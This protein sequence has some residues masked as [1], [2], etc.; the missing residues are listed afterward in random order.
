MGFAVLS[1]YSGVP[2]IVA[3]GLWAIWI[4]WSRGAAA[5]ALRAGALFS[6][7]AIGPMVLLLAYQWAAFGH[8]LFPAQRYMPPTR[9]SVY[10][11]NGMTLPTA[12]LL[13][14]NLFDP[15]YGLFVFCPMLVAA[16]AAPFLRGRPDRLARAARL[17][18]GELA[19]IFGATIA[20]LLFS[21]ANQFALLQWNTGVRYMVPAAPLLFLA[22]VSVL[23]RAPAA[24]IGLLVV[25]TVVV[26]WSVAMAREAVP[27]SLARIF[28]GGFELPWLRTLEVTADAYAPFVRQGTSP[29]PL[30]CLAA[31]VLWLVWRRL[32]RAAL[33]AGD[34]SPGS[35]TSR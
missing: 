11:W 3:F 21:S 12:E 23:L 16:L 22:L 14:R 9:Y 34:A 13:V 28:A 2:L 32:P 4:G 35:P 15:R 20:L 10:G 33:I 26:S 29:L 17:A 7:G 1:D 8:P 31:V 6:L 27:V 24:V 19:L 5:G 25:P 30:F 18:R